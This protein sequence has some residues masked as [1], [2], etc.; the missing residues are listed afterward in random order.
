[1]AVA[2]M[3]MCQYFAGDPAV[4]FASILVISLAVMYETLRTWFRAKQW[5]LRYFKASVLSVTVFLGLGAFHILMFVEF[6]FH[7]N[8]SAATTETASR[9]SLYYN[10]LISIV[11]PHFS[12]ISAYF[13]DY[14][15]R[16]SWVENNYVGVTTMV[17]ASIAIL[18]KK[19][20]MTKRHVWL[21]L[22]G[23]LL[24][25]GPWG[26]V[27]K[28]L[29]LCFPFFK[30]IRY[31]ARFMFIFSFAIACLAGF[32]LDVLLASKKD[33]K[34]GPLV[35]L[36]L[37]LVGTVAAYYFLPESMITKFYDYAKN[38]LEHTTRLE[39]T[40]EVVR[41]CVGPL[42]SNVARSVIFL[43]LT[44]VLMWLTR[45]Q[46][47]RRYLIIVF[48]VIIVFA[49]LVEANVVE[50]RVESNFLT[51]SSRSAE[52]IR[53][54]PELLRYA[55]S[56]NTMHLYR[57]APRYGSLQEA[58]WALSDGMAP[59]FHLNSRIPFM[60]GY[61]SIYLKEGVDLSKMYRDATPAQS[62]AFIDM[63]NAKYMINSDR[64]FS[65]HY[66]KVGGTALGDLC[67]N[68][69]VLPRA[70]LVEN[71]IY[72]EYE[73]TP[74]AILSGD[75]DPKKVVYLA[76]KSFEGSASNA[77]ASPASE[78]GVKI[79]HYG[80]DEAVM[81]IR[82]SK[83]QWLFFSDSYYPGWKASIDGRPTKIYQANYGFRAISVPAGFSKVAWKYEPILFRIGAIISLGSW[84][85]C[86][87]A[88]FK[89][90]RR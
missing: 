3:L 29:Y 72:L 1:M 45:T 52:V 21:A 13:M 25:L 47:A 9:W 12:D 14:W 2:L 64:S 90:R 63:V 11:I 53:K 42:L 74:K 56:P 48:L 10:D 78:D 79:V 43:V 60:G 39:W 49:D 34:N 40:P 71:A 58:L 82:S 54:D 32:G 33:H 6:L 16:Q 15:S 23:L 69:S 77:A 30:F 86:L 55:A 17:L 81:E 88:L 18:A 28:V 44:L 61:D 80:L 22:F 38:W 76:D 46:A 41:S 62:A 65:E 37:V 36:I 19:S 26:G 70:F 27:H 59:N 84:A 7:S 24:S 31:P 50:H 73:K 5:D 67:V 20:S 89:K 85:A 66:R 87:L 51:F 8:R 57:D 83:D 68:E 4:F 35:W 75:F